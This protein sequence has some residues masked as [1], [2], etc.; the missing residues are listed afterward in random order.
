MGL[1]GRPG[2]DNIDECNVTVQDCVKG[3]LRSL[4]P[5]YLRWTA[6]LI[7]RSIPAMLA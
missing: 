4:D 6:T 3:A 1:E 7:R 2:C 5:C